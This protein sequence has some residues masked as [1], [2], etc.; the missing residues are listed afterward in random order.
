[1]APSVYGST[2]LKCESNGT[3]SSLQHIL[4]D[5]VPNNGAMYGLTQ[6]KCES[7]GTPSVVTGLNA[8]KPFLHCI[9]I[10][11]TRYLETDCPIMEAIAEEEGTPEY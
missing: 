11:T 6:L 4:G 10:D 9:L 5:D 3:P 7:H 2:Q 1:M 8:G